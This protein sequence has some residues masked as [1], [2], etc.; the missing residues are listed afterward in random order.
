MNRHPCSNEVQATV[1]CQKKIKTQKFLHGGII[2]KGWL[3][4]D[5]VKR[6][7]VGLQLYC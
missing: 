7:E 3:T 2:G 6:Y 1:G 4:A 5:F